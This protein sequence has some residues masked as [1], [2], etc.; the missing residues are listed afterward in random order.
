MNK[1][2]ISFIT[3][4]NDENLYTKSLSYIKRLEIPESI[5]IEIIG[6][7]NAKSMASGYN[8]AIEK[9]DSKYKVYLHQD[10]YIKNINFIRDVLNIFKQDEK[11]GLIGM[12]GAKV[13]PFSG[14]WWDD[15]MSV[16][17]VFDS[18]TGIMGLLNL[19]EAENPYTEVRGIDGLMMISQYDLPWRDD[20][21]GG[22]HFY[23]LSQ[24]LEFIKKGFKVVVP[25]QKNAWCIHDCGLINLNDKFE[26]DKNKFLE[27]YYK[28]IFPLVSILIPT[29]NQTL[30]LQKALDSALNQTYKNTEIIICDDSTTSE[31]EKLVKQYMTKSDKIK[32]YNNGVPLGN[33][34]LLNFKKC[35]SMSSGEYISYLL[36]D[37]VYA[38]NKIE[39]MI[40]C[41]LYDNT[42]SLVTSYRKLIDKTGNYLMDNFVN[43]CQYPTDTILTGEE[44]G[45]K[46]LFSAINYIGE[47]TTVM[48]K[49]KDAPSNLFDYDK[50]KMYCLGDISLFLKLLKKGKLMYISEPLTNF[51]I[52]EGQN[53]FDNSLT[54]WSAIDFFNMIISSY[55]NKLFI[56]DKNE[57]IECLK[58]WYKWYSG[59]LIRFSDY[60]HNSSK[61]NPEII[62]LRYEYLR[63]FTKFINIMLV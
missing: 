9:S 46:L 59:D 27:S 49:R 5:E 25:K 34:G 52:H 33:K 56:K 4:V 18:N 28:D 15:P 60:Y 1:N 20:I 10:V 53:T 63:C 55:E 62:K 3:C 58:S 12:V 54:V 22:W 40:K 6:I 39:K 47:L 43:S 57:L 50:Y 21:F 17:K 61:D 37:D 35:F 26:E 41:F 13:I 24:S 7:R 38:P 23:D 51:R 11:V 8:E 44:A 36:H 48:F 30:Y 14:K 29:Y 42:L 31:V 16:G 19:K 2:K 32:Y 45:R